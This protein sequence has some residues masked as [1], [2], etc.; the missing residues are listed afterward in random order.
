MAKD[1]IVILDKESHTRWILKALLEGEK[2]IVVA[3]DTIE[4]AVQNFSEFAVSGFITEYRVG[5]ATTL[6]AIRELKRHSPEA[7]VMIL[8]ADDVAENEYEDIMDVGADDYFTK[9][10]PGWKILLHLRKGLRKRS[11][12][13]QKKALERE[14]GQLKR[15]I[16]PLELEPSEY[17]E[18]DPSGEADE[19]HP[20]ADKTMTSTP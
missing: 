6:D 18:E 2:Y 14:L 19:D 8:T 15:S 10:F 16:E 7:Y 12:L 5:Q 4:R 9:P 13:L 20:M 1:T 3:V 11:L 17:S